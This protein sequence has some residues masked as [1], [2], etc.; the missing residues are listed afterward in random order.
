MGLLRSVLPIVRLSPLAIVAA[1]KV[2][3]GAVTKPV[4]NRI[5]GMTLCSFFYG[6]RLGSSRQWFVRFDQRLHLL[7]QIEEMNN[8]A[9][10]RLLRNHLADTFRLC[11][12]APSFQSIVS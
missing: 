8:R 7:D 11:H 1:V 6:R 4:N 12:T 5:A 3:E 10:Q 9:F 2:V